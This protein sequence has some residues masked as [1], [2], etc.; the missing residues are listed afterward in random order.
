MATGRAPIFGPEAWA[1][2]GGI[3]WSHWDRWY[4]A[5]C[6]AEADGDWSRLA[7]ILAARSTR[8]HISSDSEVKLSHLD[9]LAGRLNAAGLGPVDLAAGLDKAETAKARRKVLDQGLSGRD[10]T[11]AMRQTPRRRLRERALRGSW[12]TFPVDP[13]VAY[14]VLAAD[15][16]EAGHLGKGGSFE[17]VRELEAAIAAVNDAAAA[18]PARL[19][20][21]RRAALTAVQ[22][23]A[24]RVDDSYGVIAELGES[25]WRDYVRTPWRD[26]VVAHAYWR[27][28]AELVAFD[29]YAHLHRAERLPW[30]RARKADLPLIIHSLRDLAEEYAA[31]RLPYHAD[32]ARV[33]GAYAYVATRSL[34]GYAAV[35]HDLGSE[36]WMPVVALAESALRARRP[37][38]AAA[39]FDA[40]DQPGAHRDHLRRRRAALL[41]D[42][43]GTAP[44]PSPP[45]R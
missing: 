11:A 9:D 5:V 33:A 41:T 37:D 12:A 16:E 10:L 45:G 1:D 31:A 13:S 26:L 43:K 21:A 20:A 18:D 29:D 35:A 36:H 30:R 19:L 2:I 40:A 28:V 32:Q 25:T 3:T 27:D 14:A 44:R 4:S 42:P 24:H 34:T 7:E 15:V 38:I 39:V 23:L 8:A 17:L 6:L 22:E